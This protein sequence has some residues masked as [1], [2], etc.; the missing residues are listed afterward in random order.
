MAEDN[1]DYLTRD[2]RIH[3]RDAYDLQLWSLVLGASE[4][5]VLAATV[6]VGTDARAV[7]AEL[8]RR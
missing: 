2:M 8:K 4:S 6:R 1:D 3:V 7:Q 5:E